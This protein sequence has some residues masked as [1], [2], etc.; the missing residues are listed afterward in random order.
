M[1]LLVS[2]SE[3]LA[4]ALDEELAEKDVEL[5]EAERVTNLR[6]DEIETLQKQRQDLDIKLRQS[7]DDYDEHLEQ[8]LEALV[9]ECEGLI[10][11]EQTATLARLIAEEEARDSGPLPDAVDGNSMNV[12]CANQDDSTTT[13]Q[14]ELTTQLHEAQQQRQSLV[15]QIVQDLS[16]AGV[17]DR[18]A[19]YKRLITGALNVEEKDVENMLPEIVAELEE[20]KDNAATVGS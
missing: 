4:N 16:A 15:R 7:G 14:D 17:S 10:E 1:P 18:Q 11:E 2:K 5:V 6:R 12:D 20:W 13:S 3:K 9:K 8:E 19:E